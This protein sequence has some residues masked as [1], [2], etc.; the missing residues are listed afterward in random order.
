ML[1]GSMKDGGNM[2]DIENKEMCK[3][4]FKNGETSKA[5]FT[6]TW[7]NLINQLEKRKKSE[8]SNLQAGSYHV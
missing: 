5:Q 1:S 4:V 3:S 7:I 6:K 8:S 2:S